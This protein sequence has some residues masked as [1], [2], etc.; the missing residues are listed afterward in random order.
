MEH[1]F[2]WEDIAYSTSKEILW[3]GYTKAAA[4]QGQTYCVTTRTIK[5]VC[6]VNECGCCDPKKTGKPLPVLVKSIVGRTVSPTIS[7]EKIE[8]LAKSREKAFHVRALFETRDPIFRFVMKNYFSHAIARALMKSNDEFNDAFV[9]VLAHA[10]IS[11]GA[12]TAKDWTFGR[13]IHDFSLS[14]HIS[15]PDLRQMIGPANE[16]LREGRILALRMDTHLTQLRKDVDYAIYT[17]LI[18]SS[19]ISFKRM[20]SDIER[21]YERRGMGRDVI[22]KMKKASGKGV[23]VTVERTLDGSDIR[24]VSYEFLPEQR[25]TLLRL[26]VSAGYNPLALLEAITK[27]P[28]W[29]FKAAPVY[30]DGYVQLPEDLNET[31][32][33]AALAGE[34]QKCSVT[35]GLLEIDIFTGKKMASG[36]SLAAEEGL[37]LNFPVDLEVF[38]TKEMQAIEVAAVA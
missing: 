33:F 12:N 10:R 32:V 14:E 16:V 17:I 35:G 7:A 11:A 23:F 36:V 18:P 20:R 21:F 15:E 19:L 1:I 5:G 37:D 31:D 3:R 28:A 34:E 6:H 25:G 24:K 26:V 27:R 13:N 8:E 29:T 9:G 22:V 4:F 30:C 38:S 2:P